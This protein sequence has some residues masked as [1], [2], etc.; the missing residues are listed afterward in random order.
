LLTLVNE[1]A[2]TGAALFAAGMLEVLPRVMRAHVQSENVQLHCC[3]V[4][5][6]SYEAAMPEGS[7]SN[8]KTVVPR[9]M[10]S[11][12]DACLT[13]METHLHAHLLQCICL[14]LLL[15]LA[16]KGG[17]VGNTMGARIARALVAAMRAHPGAVGPSCAA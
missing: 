14:Q 17:L 13:A 5:M 4:L 10:L 9:A 16:L 6:T 3:H 7:D 12:A 2:P 8:D 11:A 1:H 15:R